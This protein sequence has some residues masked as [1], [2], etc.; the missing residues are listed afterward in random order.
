MDLIPDRY[1]HNP[2]LVLVENFVLDAIGKLEPDKAARLE[3]IVNRTFG[4]DDWRATLRNYLALPPDT[5]T[6]LQTLWQQRQAE[7]DLQQIDFSAEGFAREQADQL[8]S[9]LGG[10]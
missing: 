6:T 7:A 9:D 1:E 5:Q 3:E 2:M 10:T 4:G 8:F